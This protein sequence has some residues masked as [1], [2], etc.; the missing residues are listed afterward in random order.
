M[1]LGCATCS[2]LTGAPGRGHMATAAAR[3]R[4]WYWGVAV[5]A[6]VWATAGCFAYVSQVSMG[7]T[8]LARLPVAQAE[9]W[10]MMPAWVTAAYAVA[11]WAGFGGAAGLL[12]RRRWAAHAYALS[13]A[14]VLT[15]F[16]WTFLATP[17]LRTV[18]LSAVG[19][20]AFIAA[21][22][23]LLLWFSITAERRGWLG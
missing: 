3:V 20:P 11:V 19:F 22:G 15:Q 23:I 14:G 21:A 6:F 12:M 10:R 5:L 18:G 2:I 1:Q 8:E 17:I 9:I 4:G 7:E 13:L 16:G